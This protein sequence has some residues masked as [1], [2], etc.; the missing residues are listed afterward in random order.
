MHPLFT[1]HAPMPCTAQLAHHHIPILTPPNPG[2]VGLHDTAAPHLPTNAAVEVFV[3]EY[4][5][6][7]FLA[8]YNTEQVYMELL[9]I[10]LL[11]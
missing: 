6:P 1:T 4:L 10:N 5:L 11:K 8:V 9:R 7:N 3:A 2:P